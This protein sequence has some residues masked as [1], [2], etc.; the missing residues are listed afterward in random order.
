[1]GI[2]FKFRMFTWVNIAWSTLLKQVL[3][4]ANFLTNI[5]FVI[6]RTWQAWYSNRV[7]G[8]EG[9]IR[10]INFHRLPKS[11]EIGLDSIPTSEVIISVWCKH[12][13]FDNRCLL[14]WDNKSLFSTLITV[15]Q[16]Y[17]IIANDN[18]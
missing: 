11:S 8:P 3:T 10:S 5:E 4:K 7:A 2:S 12:K 17:D 16:F 6:S 1:M 15:V 9:P 18:F 13:H 14:F